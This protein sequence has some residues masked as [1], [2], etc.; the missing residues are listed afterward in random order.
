M[1]LEYCTIG[2]AKNYLRKDVLTNVSPLKMV[3]SYPD[4]VRCLRVRNEE[5]EGVCV[6]LDPNASYYD[7]LR[8]GDKETIVFLSIANESAGEELVGSL[9]VKH[10]A[11]F[12]LNNDIS[13]KVVSRYFKLDR[14]RAISFYT[15]DEI[16]YEEDPNVKVSAEW[17][18]QITDLIKEHEYPDNEIRD[19]LKAGAFFVSY[20]VGDVV[21]CACICYPNCQEV[22]EVGALF[23]LDE[24]RRKGLARK[25]VAQGISELFKQNRKIRY[26][27][28]EENIKSAQ[29]AESLGLKK[30]QVLE[31]FI[32]ERKAE[33]TQSN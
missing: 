27:V 20:W 14:Q 16:T 12:K 13:K 10:N 22:W 21:A 9:P 33:V 19:W 32:G 2:Q 1:G 23:T 25:V 26:S 11:A 8:Y 24:Y 4:G 7:N 15:C 31:H 28:R 29:L 5:A 18:K 17:D 30:F 6:L 3:V